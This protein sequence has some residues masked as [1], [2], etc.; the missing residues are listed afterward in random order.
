[1]KEQRKK[2]IKGR[3]VFLCALVLF[4]IIN[5]YRWNAESAAG[6]RMPMPLGIGCSVVLSDS[7]VPA[8]H[9]DDL[10]FIRKTNDVQVNDIIVFQDGK[11]LVIH[12]VVAI[13][14]DMLQ[15]K[16]D[17]NNTPD[18]PIHI[19]AV[20]GKLFLT[21]PGVGAVFQTLRQPWIITGLL[22]MALLLTVLSNQKE[23]AVDAQEKQC[24][25]KGSSNESNI[26]SQG[27]SR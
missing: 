13:K 21:I 10:V 9:T 20:K 17:A 15:T 23:S 4:L 2:N 7:M 5:V 14:G 1:M 3:T 25:D 16:G 12:R 8:L 18:V 24:T 22:G 6:N 27:G 26:D 19:S 11:M